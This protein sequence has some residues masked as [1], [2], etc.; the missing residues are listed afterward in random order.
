MPCGFSEVSPFWLV[1]YQLPPNL[2]ELC[3]LFGSL[4]GPLVFPS[5]LVIFVAQPAEYHSAYAQLSIW[6]KTQRIFSLGFFFCLAPSFFAQCP[7]NSSHLE[8]S[9]FQCLPPLFSKAA[10]L[11][12]LALP[13]PQSAKYLQVDSR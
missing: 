12:E 5:S 2:C 11:C 4:I 13:P 9:E 10:G 6:S 3:S 8:S 7:L 1:G